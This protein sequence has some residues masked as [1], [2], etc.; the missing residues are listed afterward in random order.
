[1]LRKT[2][3]E[4]D[5]D[6]ISANY[7]T[8]QNFDS[9]KTI[10][11]V[12]KAD[13]Y[14]HGVLKV[15]EKL[16]K[17]N[18]SFFA[19]SL[20]EEA[21]EI[22]KVYKDID[23]LVMGTTD[24]ESIKVCAKNNIIFTLFDEQ[25]FLKIIRLDIPLRFHIKFD[26]GMNRLGFKSPFKLIKIVEALRPYDNL[27]FEGIFTHFATS[28]FK[29]DTY[30]KKQLSAFE[31][32][33]KNLPIK[34]K[35][36]HTSNS[37]AI[38]KYEKDIQFTTHSRLG[39]SLYGL[40]LDTKKSHL[41]PALKL[42]SNIVQIKKLKPGD[43]VGYGITYE[44]QKEELIGILPIGYADGFIRNNQSGVVSIHKR[45][46]PIVG[47]ICMDHTFV[48]IDESVNLHDEVVL[49]GD[50]IVSVDDVA[51]RLNTI[52]Y[53]VITTLTNRVPRVYK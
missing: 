13:A 38:L 49:M 31:M 7:D 25:Q 27:S 1:M 19:V 23:I 21:L 34:P 44:A 30:F 28:D 10:I 15:V 2:Y 8:Y 53:E 24:I 33:L 50:D 6:A 46:Y 22:R 40:S 39:I 42:I 4:I 12:V 47:R 32:V 3:T 52:N 41:K 45:K 37:S 5:L 48:K 43:K 18:V 35:M 17:K 9:S 51:E 14:G 26:S 36:I 11:P 16:I 20:V 29:D